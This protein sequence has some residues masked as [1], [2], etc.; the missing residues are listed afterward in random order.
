MRTL[1]ADFKFIEETE[2]ENFVDHRWC[3]LC[4]GMEDPLVC[5][6]VRFVVY[7][8]NSQLHR[9]HVAVGNRR[10]SCEFDRLE[11]KQANFF[12]LGFN[13]VPRE[14]TR[15]SLASLETNLIRSC[16][17]FEVTKQSGS[18]TSSSNCYMSLREAR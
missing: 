6:F 15:H 18:S 2:S 10:V 1:H 12:F 13:R 5:T 4:Q 9:R 11:N 17:K 14:R 16:K 8:W 7:L 3:L